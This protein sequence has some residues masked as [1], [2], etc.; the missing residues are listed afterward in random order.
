MKFSFLLSKNVLSLFNGS[1]EGVVI[2]GYFDEKLKKLNYIGISSQDDNTLADEYVLNVKNIYSIGQDAITIKNNSLL[3]LKDTLIIDDYTPINSF[4]YLTN[5]TFIGK[6]NDVTLDNKFNIESYTIENTEISSSKVA[7]H[8][9]GTIIFYDENFNVK[10]E[11]FKPS[12]KIK[13]AEN[14]KNTNNLPKTI[15][16]PIFKN[17]EINKYETN[18][19]FLTEN[20]KSDKIDEKIQ[21]NIEIN[22]NLE[23]IER[24]T[25]NSNLLI[26]KKITKTI[27][28][29]NGELIGKKGNIVTNKTIILATAHQKLRELV[30]YCE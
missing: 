4:A 6:V 2:A 23:K 3:D 22:A 13:L 16:M 14:G 26:G 11:K 19:D 20:L 28:T 17:D 30:L 18:N 1:N 24:L 15:F 25:A 9:K 8:S 21:K 10:I 7:S 27:S 5:G 29:P 12:S